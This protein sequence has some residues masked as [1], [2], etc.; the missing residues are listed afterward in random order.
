M[1]IKELLDMEVDE[2][3]KQP[4][5]TEKALALAIYGLHVDGV[6][7]KQWFLERI[8]DALGSDLAEAYEYGDWEDG[9]SP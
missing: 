1:T 3:V 5:S 8:I 7:Y 2:L 6:H 4:P 9:I